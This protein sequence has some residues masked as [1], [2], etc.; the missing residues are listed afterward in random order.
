MDRYGMAVLAPP[1]Q[2]KR[3]IYQIYHPLFS[4]LFII[5]NYIVVISTI[6][7]IVVTIIDHIARISSSQF[8]PLLQEL[9]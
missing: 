5:D 7:V 6:D 2:V 3:V 1:S 4:Q 9:R 8:D